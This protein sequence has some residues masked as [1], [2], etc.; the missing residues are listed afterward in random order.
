M[1]TAVQIDGVAIAE[2]EVDTMDMLGSVTEPM[3]NAA[4]CLPDASCTALACHDVT[5]YW[6]GGEPD[7]SFDMALTLTL[8]EGEK[9]APAITVVFS[10]VKV[11]P[12]PAST[13]DD[14]IATQAITA[15]AIN[16]F[17]PIILF[18]YPD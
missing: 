12:L 2:R 17:F 1:S 4:Y 5:Q 8:V 16:V 6:F 15:S 13:T 14:V 7:E 10:L 3:L 11:T 18:F 9:I